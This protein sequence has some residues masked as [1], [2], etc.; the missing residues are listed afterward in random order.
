[1]PTA[2][3]PANIHRPVH[4]PFI[5]KHHE[6]TTRTTTSLLKRL[7]RRNDDDAKTHYH[8]RSTTPGPA[9]DL[10]HTMPNRDPSHS[11]HSVSDAPPH[12]SE[13]IHPL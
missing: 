1:M 8:R 11:P 4:H 7:P 6:R 5:I 12:Y 10:Y 3:A 2:P 9:L 13:R